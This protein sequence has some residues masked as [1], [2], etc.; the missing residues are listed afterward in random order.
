MNLNERITAVYFLQRFVT[1]SQAL[2]PTLKKLTAKRKLSKSET[3]ELKSITEIYDSFHADPN[4]SVELVNSS[5]ISL[6]LDVYKQ[7]K[8][9]NGETPESI[10]RY[11]A[12]W[13]E[14]TRLVDTWNR[15]LMN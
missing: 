14:S 1:M 11:D 12:F 2:L 8:Q 5:I 3:E 7:I 4:I 9:R 15:Q 10:Y 13:N 6:I